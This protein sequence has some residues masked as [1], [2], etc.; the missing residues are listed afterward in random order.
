MHEGFILFISDRTKFFIW[1]AKSLRSNYQEGNNLS[2]PFLFIVCNSSM[3][4]LLFR[5]II[6]TVTRSHCVV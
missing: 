1:K 6:G 2:V 3:Y 4:C 5:N